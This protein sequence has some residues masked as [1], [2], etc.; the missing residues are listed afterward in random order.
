MRPV[1]SVPSP[2]PQIRHASSLTV[3]NKM[4]VYPVVPMQE[5][6]ITHRVPSRPRVISGF[7]S[8]EDLQRPIDVVPMVPVYETRRTLQTSQVTTPISRTVSQERFKVMVETP[9]RARP[10][11]EPGISSELLHQK[12]IEVTPVVP[13][14]RTQREA[15]V[16][17][18]P[19]LEP[20]YTSEGEIERNIE[21]VPM[22]PSYRTET[23]RPVPARPPLEVGYESKATLERM[24]QIEKELTEVFSS[25]LS[26]SKIHCEGIY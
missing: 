5:T 25:N 4:Q 26:S 1:E 15:S 19:T 21:V 10:Q 20:G 22:V 7:V 9:I 12:T 23:E 16:A 3:L 18:Q 24:M 8:T 13:M 14:Y 2:T 6:T 11:L 17:S